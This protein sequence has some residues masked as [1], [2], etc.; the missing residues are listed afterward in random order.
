MTPGSRDIILETCLQ[1]NGKLFELHAVV[2]MPD[3]VH[4]VITLLVDDSGEISLPEIMQTINSASAHRINKYLGRKDRVWQ[5]ES[6]DRAMREVENTRGK[7][8]YLLGNPVRAG[9]ASS[10]HEYLWLWTS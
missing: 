6:S 1:G 9:L 8:E 5:E 3:H 10:L 2:V 4:L 7:I